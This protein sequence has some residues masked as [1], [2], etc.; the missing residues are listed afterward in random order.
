MEED[1]RNNGKRPEPIDM[2]KV[3]MMGITR[4][5]ENG[6]RL[7]LMGGVGR[8]SAGAPTMYGGGWGGNKS[9]AGAPIGNSRGN[10]GPNWFELV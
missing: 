1:Y 3:L 4:R 9:E 8:H 5:P 10:L 6:G 7:R 2:A